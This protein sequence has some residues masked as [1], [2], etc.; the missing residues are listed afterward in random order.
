MSTTYR[1]RRS[2]FSVEE[3]RATSE[4]RKTAKRR[5]GAEW[6]ALIDAIHGKRIRIQ[7]ACIVWWDF[8]GNE[9]ANAGFKELDDLRDDWTNE[10]NADRLSV[11]EALVAIGYQ[12][13]IADKRTNEDVWMGFSMAEGRRRKTA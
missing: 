7:V 5:T 3:F 13:R 12:Q 4:W 11:R 6:R 10:Q 2:P 1:E 8:A 9:Y